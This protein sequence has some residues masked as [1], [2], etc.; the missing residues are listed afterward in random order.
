MVFVPG[1][2][3]LDRLEARRANSM[4]K[5][6]SQVGC[7]LVFI[8]L[9]YSSISPVAGSRTA[10]AE[11]RSGRMLPRRLGG[12]RVKMERGCGRGEGW[13]GVTLGRGEG[14]RCRR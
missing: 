3:S 10:L 13:G 14:G 6:F 11:G 4:D 8:I 1:V 7:C 5:E 2:L 12:G 9:R